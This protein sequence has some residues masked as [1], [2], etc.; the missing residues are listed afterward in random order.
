MAT[1]CEPTITLFNAIKSLLPGLPDDVSKLTLTLE[2]GKMPLVECTFCPAV[3]GEVSVPAE[4]ITCKYALVP[5]GETLSGEQGPELVSFS[6][7]SKVYGAGNLQ[8]LTL[9]VDAGEAVAA[10]KAA[11][12][13]MAQQLRGGVSALLDIAGNASAEMVKGEA[14]ALEPDPRLDEIVSLLKEL[15]AHAKSEREEARAAAAALVMD[16]ARP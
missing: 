7:P 11:T 10:I 13:N 15:V 12:E 6:Q 5:V 1:I 2:A 8:A 4:L 3:D 16:V 9:K 14:L